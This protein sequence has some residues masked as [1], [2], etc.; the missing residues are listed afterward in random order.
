MATIHLQ[1]EGIVSPPV[2]KQV[3]T[4]FVL[5]RVYAGRFHNLLACLANFNMIKKLPRKRIG[6]PL[7]KFAIAGC[8]KT[9]N[10]WPLTLCGRTWWKA[11][12]F[13]AFCLYPF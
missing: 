5:S 3:V 13:S 7:Y 1:V 10:S 2:R 12:R 8:E 11:Q 9:M 6:S 4:Q